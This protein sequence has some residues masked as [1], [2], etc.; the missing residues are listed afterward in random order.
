MANKLFHILVAVVFVTLLVLLTDPLMVWMPAPAQ[1]LALLSA[2]VLAAV[3][4][5]FVMYEHVHDEREAIHKEAA[6]RV[7][8]L[9]GVAL[10]TIA[11]VVQG[12]AH[13]IDPWVPLA[14]GGMV[15][16]KLAARLYLER[17]R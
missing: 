2:A 4:A 7:A 8:Y 10:L 16:A 3:W 1:M 5:G 13:A 11:L 12:L 17:Y 14:L 9:S 15:L 6:G